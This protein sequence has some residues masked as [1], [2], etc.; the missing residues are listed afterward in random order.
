MEQVSGHV[1]LNQ[2][3]VCTR[4]DEHIS[5]NMSQKY[6]IQ[7][8]CATTPGQ[9]CPLLILE[10]CLFNRHCWVNPTKDNH[11][12]LG[13][14]PTWAIRDQSTSYGFAEMQDFACSLLTMSGSLTSTCPHY[15]K[16][17]FDILTNIVLGNGDLR[18]ILNRGFQVDPD[19]ALGLSARNSN[20]SALTKSVNS[21]EMVR[22]LSASQEYIK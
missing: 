6:F 4:R 11:S 13:G 17:W 14:L 8:F 21:Q 2:A 10:G 9:A 5:G 19:T 15:F 1:L 3:A 16:H 12:L 22:A 20:G 7:R 18:H